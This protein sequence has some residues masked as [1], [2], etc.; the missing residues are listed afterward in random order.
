MSTINPFVIFATILVTLYAG[1]GAWL[2]FKEK[3]TSNDSKAVDALPPNTWGKKVINHLTVHHF[4]LHSPLIQ[5]LIIFLWC[6]SLEMFDPYLGGWS[7]GILPIVFT[8]L[9]P[10]VNAFFPRWWLS[11]GL[12]ILSWFLLVFALIG[13]LPPLPDPDIGD[14]RGMAF[15]IP[16]ALCGLFLPLSA[17]LRFIVI[18]QKSVAKKA[19]SEQQT[20][21]PS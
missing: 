1:T 12:F 3:H 15:V 18:K 4:Y 7:I 13:I 11:T 6:D 17:I 16:M 9:S 19:P 20:E 14:T 8:V 5:A 21:T 2:I 10:I